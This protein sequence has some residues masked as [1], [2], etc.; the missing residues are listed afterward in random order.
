MAQGFEE[1]MASLIAERTGMG[2]EPSQAPEPPAQEQ[3]IQHSHAEAE[4]YAEPEQQSET[5]RQPESEPY[6]KLA[7]RK[8]EEEVADEEEFVNRVKG[9]K[10][11]AVQD[12]YDGD[13][14]LKRLAD[15]RKKGGDPKFF[16]ETQTLD[17]DAMAKDNPDELLFLDLKLQKGDVL[18]DSQIRRFIKNQYKTSTDDF[19]LTED[20]A[21]MNEINKALAIKEAK[22]RLGEWKVQSAVPPSERQRQQEEAK[23]EA[24]TARYLERLRTINPEM[25]FEVEGKKYNL[26]VRDKDLKAAESPADFISQFLTPEGE[27]D[28]IKIARANFILNGGYADLVKA[29]APEVASK[30]IKEVVQKIDNP[31]TKRTEK[32]SGRGSNNPYEDLLGGVAK[33]FFGA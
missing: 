5:Q 9:Y 6:W 33:D 27:F 30:G 12:P 26:K 8:L 11:R 24:Q 19:D 14:F 32:P 1:E 29:S 10:E 31:S 15:Y 25:G 21:E 2:A 22:V 20:E 28:P 23:L 3:P 13:E 18:S 17:L 16:I 7:S 4:T